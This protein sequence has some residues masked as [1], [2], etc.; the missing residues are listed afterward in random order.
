MLNFTEYNDCLIIY[1]PNMSQEAAEKYYGERLEM[2]TNK[3]YLVKHQMDESGW[4]KT[5]VGHLFKGASRALRSK[6]LA[7]LIGGGEWLVTTLEE[8]GMGEVLISKDLKTIYEI[9]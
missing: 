3:I 9:A 1:N 8:F 6:W 7:M 2:F 5:V 4:T